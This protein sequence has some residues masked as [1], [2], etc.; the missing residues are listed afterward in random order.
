VLLR[1]AALAA[2]SALEI[3]E[4][5]SPGF[6]RIMRAT[7]AEMEECLSSLRLSVFVWGAGLLG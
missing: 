6:G 4:S 5:T 7:R 3:S 2:V 1:S